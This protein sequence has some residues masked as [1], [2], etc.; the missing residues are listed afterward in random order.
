MINKITFFNKSDVIGGAEHFLIDVI[1]ILKERGI[2]S[3]IKCNEGPLADYLSELQIDHE[4]IEMPRI[5]TLKN[6]FNF[7][8][9]AVKYSRKINSQNTIIS[10]NYR[11]HIFLSICRIFKKFNFICIY[12]DFS[13]NKYIQHAIGF[14]AFKI[15]VV[16]KFLAEY[17]NLK[18]YSIVPNFVNP[19]NI[20]YCSPQKDAGRFT[21]TLIARIVKL[22]G[23]EYF[24]NAYNHLSP[25]L[26]AKTYFW[27]VGDKHEEEAEYYE[28]LKSNCIQGGTEKNIIFKGY[29]RDI[30][31]VL[32]ESDVVVS[33]SISEFGGPESFGRTVIEAML[34]GKPVVSTNVGGPRDIIK[35]GFNGML[36]EQKNSEAIAAA[37]E[38]LLKDRA[39]YEKIARNGFNTVIN[40][41]DG[42][43]VV[44]KLLEDIN[45]S[46]AESENQYILR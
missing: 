7:I 36:V 25:E 4:I 1:A 8:W 29:R 12:H 23:I 19:A 45:I 20:A 2:R 15:F 42:K 3:E 35:N 26:K 6:A 27:I 17:Y 38:K 13:Y 21:V 34:R 32:S 33:S 43:F 14:F 11:S 40:R 39:F 9:S 16:S 5:N 37:V 41:Y 31:K 24:I 46:F 28:V 22:K 18:K 44:R 10:N 30:D